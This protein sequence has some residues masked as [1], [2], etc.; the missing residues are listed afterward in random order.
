MQGER[1]DKT[2]EVMLYLSLENFTIY[3][4]KLKLKNSQQ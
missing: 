3:N 2:L 1:V 4:F